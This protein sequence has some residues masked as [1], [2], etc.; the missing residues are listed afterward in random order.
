MNKSLKILKICNP[1]N[2]LVRKSRNYLAASSSS[3][4]ASVLSFNSRYGHNEGRGS[5][6]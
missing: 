2:Y 3:G 4:G 5:L 1:N 6:H